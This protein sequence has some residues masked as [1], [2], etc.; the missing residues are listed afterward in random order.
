M[1]GTVLG[2][3][4]LAIN[5]MNQDL[6][7]MGLTFQWGRQCTNKGLHNIMSVAL[8]KK[9]QGKKIENSGDGGYSSEGQE[10]LL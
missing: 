3:W 1:P 4:D 2:A 5:R 10:R 7:L 6:I 9:K 8:K